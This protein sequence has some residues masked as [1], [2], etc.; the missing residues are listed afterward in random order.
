M[1]AV[2]ARPNRSGGV[3]ASGPRECLRGGR[4]PVGPDQGEEN[5]VR[6]VVVGATG[7]IGVS[8][9]ER[10]AADPGVDSIVGVARRVPRGP[11]EFTGA[12]RVSWVPAD[13]RHDD[14][15]PLVRDA[16]VV[17]HLAWMFQPTHRPEVTWSANAVGTSRLIDAV[18]AAGVPALVVS[19]SVAAYSPRA[20]TDLVDESWPT[21]GTSPAAYAREKAYVERLLDAAEATGHLRVVRI[22]PA[23]VFQARSASE[24]QRIFG[25]PLLPRTLVRPGLIP[26]L[27]V[28]TS[29]CL[30]AVHAQDVADAFARAALTDVSGGFNICADD[31]LGPP[32]LTRLFRARRVPVPPAVLRGLINAAWT[33]RAIPADPKLFDAVMELPMMS[34]ARAGAELGWRPTRSAEDVLK[35][36]L[37]GLREGKGERTAP[38]HPSSSEQA[39]KA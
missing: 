18:H 3:T 13:I 27:P 5:N 21:H 28:P 39:A 6:V 16:D 12:D 32:E 33:A 14:L 36:F 7:N 17:V 11:L 10:L 9:V 19:S 2:A 31:I 24:Q 35:E 30:Q 22:R 26:A 37:A 29:L 34:N 25:G 8:L 15:E 38:L 23:F 4:V 20:H 1:H